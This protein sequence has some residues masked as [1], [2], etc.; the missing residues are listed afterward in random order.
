MS[1]TRPMRAVNKKVVS[2]N[3]NLYDE[4]GDANNVFPKPL[5]V[6]DMN[7]LTKEAKKIRMSLHP[8]YI[9][10][11]EDKLLVKA[12]EIRGCKCSTEACPNVAKKLE[13]PKH[14]KR[15][16]RNQN[17]RR[18][19]CV[20]LVVAD[21]GDKGSGVY[22]LEELKKGRFLCAYFGDLISPDERN[23]R[24]ELYKDEGL[25][26][27]YTFQ[28]G[29]FFI[30][31]TKRGNIAKYANHSCIP[32]M[33]AIT[34]KLDGHHKNLMVIGY[35]AARN[36]GIGEELTVAYNFDYDPENSQIC[37]C[38]AT[39]C[40]GFMG[41]GPKK[42]DMVAEIPVRVPSKKTGVIGRVRNT[43]NVFKKQQ[44]P[45]QANQPSVEALENDENNADVARNGENEQIVVQHVDHLDQEEELREQIAI[46]G[47]ERRTRSYTNDVMKKLK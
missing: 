15:G 10:P 41:K 22:A 14:C 9:I 45:K 1:S 28:A 34:Y 39:S 36:I 7:D 44:V 19:T 40:K 4:D 27:D 43:K 25:P 18:N 8:S 30:D 11:D 46:L 38:G 31:P 29:S 17:F 42:E 2:Y 47:P 37:L 6:P 12:C 20:D 26:H 3:D 13:C 32:N 35:F 23:R 21:A 5:P 16:C 24:K 33:V